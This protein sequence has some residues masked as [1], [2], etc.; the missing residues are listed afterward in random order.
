MCMNS[1]KRVKFSH[2]SK[3]FTSVDSKILIETLENNWFQLTN[4]SAVRNCLQRA[5][6]T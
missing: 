4:K 3:A 6:S 1:L 2:E 5:L